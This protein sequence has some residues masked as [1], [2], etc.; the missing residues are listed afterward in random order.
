MT[1]RMGMDNKIDQRKFTLPS[2]SLVAFLYK[3]FMF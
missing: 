3:S 1:M 2:E